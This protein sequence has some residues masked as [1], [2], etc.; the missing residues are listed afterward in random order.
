MGFTTDRKVKL[1]HNVSRLLGA[2]RTK[3]A[4][5]CAMLQKADI[6]LTGE[7]T[8]H[9]D[10][11]GMTWVKKYHNF[12]ADVRAHFPLHLPPQAPNPLSPPSSPQP[13]T[14]K[15]TTWPRSSSTRWVSERPPS[16]KEA[17]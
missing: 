1:E 17:S 7:P 10:A 4:L 13:L 16:R 15:R 11:I 8:N 12:L 6:F 9:L 2:C 14:K 3:L 5:T